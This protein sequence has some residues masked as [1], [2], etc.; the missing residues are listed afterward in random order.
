MAE[1]EIVSVEFTEQQL[2]LID[3]LSSKWGLPRQAVVGRV[4]QEFLREQH[5]QP[6]P[7]RGESE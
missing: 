3:R 4:F 5:N 1:Q 6:Q 2:E 7:H